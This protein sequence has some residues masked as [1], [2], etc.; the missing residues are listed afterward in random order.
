MDNLMICTCRVR[1]NWHLVG[2]TYKLFLTVGTC[3]RGMVVILCV[4]TPA[5]LYVAKKAP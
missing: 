5:G 2:D 3:A 1:S 4:T